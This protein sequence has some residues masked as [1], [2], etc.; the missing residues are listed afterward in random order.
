MNFKIS[1]VERLLCLC[2]RHCDF[3]EKEKIRTLYSE[4]GDCTVYNS[5]KLNKVESIVAHALS[6]CLDRSKL[7]AHWSQEYKRTE[8]KIGSY[9]EELNKAAD[10]LAEYNIPLLALKNSG[11]SIGLY[12]YYGACPMGDVDVLVRK[13]QFRE[14]H[15]V[16]VDNGYKLKFRC[17]FEEEDI[18]AAER[19][20]G[21]E[22][23]VHLDNGEH[24]W[25]E[26]QWRPIAGRWIQPNQEPKV[27]DLV[28]RSIPI[29]GSSVRLLSPEDNLLQV[30][31]HTAKHTFVRAPGFRL[32]T[33][34]DR[35]IATQH[36]NWEKF[37]TMV[38]ELRI[39]TAVYVSLSMAHD[40]LG[41]NVPSHVLG[42][43][44]PNALKIKIIQTWLMRVGIFEPDAHKWTKVG[45][46]VF[47]S[48][49]YDT[50]RDFFSGIFPSSVD[51]KSQY[52]Y[53][54]ALLTPYYYGKRLLNMIFKR[55][56]V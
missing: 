11:I 55:A 7:P 24:L 29:R 20:G 33:D 45:Y 35:I 13:S 15:R 50:W 25:F 38:L 3:L 40:L 31:L 6:I 5:A 22:Y 43:I 54:N 16:L 27:D 12:P 52:G 42:S 48:L 49:L 51:M 41:T 44:K 8:N 47:V 21:A 14:A 19:G 23:S 56:K 39:K 28:D 2:I 1:K 46:I 18:E 34:V 30:A 36:I 9:M 32:H 53:S 26:L 4:L 37:E 10:L 17:E